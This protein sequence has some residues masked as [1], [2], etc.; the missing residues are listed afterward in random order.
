MQCPKC[1]YE[2]TMA[3]M[4]SS[5]G[6]CA[7][8][9]IVYEK[10]D[11]QS[12]MAERRAKRRPWLLSAVALVAVVALTVGGL[13]FHTHQQAIEQID[14]Q[15]KLAT[16]YVEQMAA[17]SSGASS[18]TF[19]ELFS[20][21]DRF[22]G[23]IDSALVKVSIVE[24]RLPEAEAAQ[25]YM[26]AGQEVI[27]N[28]SGAARSMMEFGT[29]KDREKRAIEDEMSSNSYRRER[30]SEMKLK[31]LDDQIKALDAMKVKQNSLRTSAKAMLAAQGSLGALS[32]SSLLSQ[33]L[34]ARLVSD[35]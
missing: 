29:A 34:Q 6:Q 33:D 17:V 15:V 20:K 10:Y 1:R 21:A 16:A 4:Q 35:K 31:A 3:E 18:M 12:H 13:K 22:I 27:R 26:K 8:C 9:G 32:A 11:D 14:A 2:P 19:G 24:P 30:A 5:P 7:S 28:I 23:E 25:A